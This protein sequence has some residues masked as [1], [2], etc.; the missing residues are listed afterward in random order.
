MLDHLIPSEQLP[1]VDAEEAF[2]P[3]ERASAKHT[4][5]AKI[6]TDA[7]LDQ[8]GANDTVTIDP[9]VEQELAAKTFAIMA[10]TVPLPPDRVEQQ[11]KEAVLSLN[12]SPAVKAI[13]TMLSAYQWE[14]VQQA[15][16]IRAFVVASLLE[17]AQGKQPGNRLKALKLLGDITEVGLF[18]Q[19]VQVEH[20]TD[21]REIEA[22]LKEKL[23]AFIGPEI[24]DVEDAVESSTTPAGAEPFIDDVLSD[25]NER[26]TD[27]GT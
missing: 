5:D 10:G 24:T 18:T 25:K 19:K 27:D 17:E 23:K 20:K 3:L 2:V 8:L 13:S 12:T 11:R 7:W 26:Q 6:K 1:R 21:E 15:H 14:F 16:E 22:R 9:L 4:L